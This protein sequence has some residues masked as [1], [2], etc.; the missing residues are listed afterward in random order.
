MPSTRKSK[1]TGSGKRRLEFDDDD[2]DH[3][4]N[5]QS[6]VADTTSKSTT[7][8][9]AVTPMKKKKLNKRKVTDYFASPSKQPV[10][11]IA[12]TTPSKTLSSSSSLSLPKAALVTPMEK[13]SKSKVKDESLLSH[14]GEDNEYIPKYLNK[15]VDYYRK[16]ETSLDPVT[17]QVFELVSKYYIIPEKFETSRTFGSKSGTSF[18]RRV[19]SAYATKQLQS[20]EE[21][22]IVEICTSCASVGH[23]NDDCPEQI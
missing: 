2:D 9:N 13:G 8:S 21:T 12:T 18:E 10:T 3:D 1:S 4:D 20:K 19:I 22:I 15:N 7:T 5:K 16:G 6:V 23:E 11:S 17:A 14:P